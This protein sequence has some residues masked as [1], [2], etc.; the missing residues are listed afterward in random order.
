MLPLHL[1]I[2]ILRPFFQPAFPAPHFRLRPRGA[3]TTA[4]AFAILCTCVCLYDVTSL[5]ARVGEDLK[6]QSVYSHQHWWLALYVRIRILATGGDILV[7]FL[8]TKGYCERQKEVHICTFNTRGHVLEKAETRF[9]RM[10][11]CEQTGY[12]TMVAV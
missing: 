9:E 8:N 11:I 6:M 1:Y 10:A 7:F 12:C 3:S 2:P 5:M 4:F